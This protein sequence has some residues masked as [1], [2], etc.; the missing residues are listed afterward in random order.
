[1][2]LKDLLQAVVTGDPT[3]PGH[4]RKRAWETLEV[5][6]IHY[7]AQ[8]VRPGGLFVAV[9]GFVADGHAFVNQAV[10][11]GA[12][13]VVAQQP[14]ACEAVV[15]QVPETRRT[16]ALLA[17]RFYGHPSRRLFI[18][19]I[20]GT[21]GKTT[22]AFL[23]EQILMQQGFK[24]GVIGTINYRYAGKI[25]ENPVTTPESLDLQRILAEMASAGVT[26]VVMEVSSHAIDLSRIAGCQMDIGVFTNLSQDHLDYHGSMD[27]YWACKKKFFTEHL[28]DSRAHKQVHAVINGDDPRGRE[29]AA[30]LDL[31]LLVTGRSAHAD[32]RSPA[33]MCDLDGIRGRL[34]TPQGEC[35]IT[36]S[37]IG[38]HNV[39]NILSA[40]GVGIAA[41]VPLETIRAG[42]RATVCVP[43][44]LEKI[45]PG[46][47]RHVYVDYAH[48]PAA[49]E[50][51]LTAL[52]KLTAQRLLCVFGCGGNRDRGKRP[53]MGRIA[54]MHSDL[55]IITSDNP[56]REEP[57]DII[58]QIASGIA[59]LGLPRFG[60]NALAQGFDR[61][62]YTIEPDRQS[63][64]RLAAAVSRPGD[65]LLI[66]G[67]GH[68]TYQILGDRTIAFDDREQVRRALETAS[69][70]KAV[71][72]DV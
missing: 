55:T 7:R 30:E 15:I 21:N 8:E 37:L 38:A 29:L 42:I 27:S 49:L 26:H 48:T 57:L 62:G 39:E 52:K 20:T 5:A 72:A 4:R 6:S 10:S 58:A 16:L 25:F 22:T 60:K 17:D 23:V 53:Q 12:V 11:R 41:G 47:G 45:A 1:V 69:M 3:V 66:A 68:E 34:S 19:G 65:T 35:E 50:N 54:G 71:N 2:K 40:A 18:V 67:K 70:D 14:L 24:V 13:A 56:R 46:S 61:K 9:K 63:A 36:S 43:G 64:I 32:V 44:R 33:V 31:P 59:A 51:V 28:M